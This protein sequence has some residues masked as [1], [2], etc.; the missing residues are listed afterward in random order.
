MRHG[1][2]VFLPY[3]AIPMGW[4][5]LNGGCNLSNSLPAQHLLLVYTN[6]FGI[7]GA[8]P[9]ALMSVRAPRQ[10]VGNPAHQE[11]RHRDSTADLIVH[12]QADRELTACV[13]GALHLRSEMSTLP[14]GRDRKL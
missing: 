10:R 9:C 2:D 6:K 12:A 7:E 5:Y 8:A 1:I 14:L 3:V 11:P 4:V 13:V